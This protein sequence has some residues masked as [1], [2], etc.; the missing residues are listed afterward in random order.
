MQSVYLKDK[1]GSSV[2]VIQTKSWHFSE[3][4]T[5]YTGDPGCEMELQYIYEKIVL[6][7]ITNF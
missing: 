2:S 4:K 3:N 1:E 5:T 7:A 6:K